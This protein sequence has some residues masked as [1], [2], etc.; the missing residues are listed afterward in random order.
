MTRCRLVAL[1]VD[2]TLMSYDGVIS[3]EVRA[4]VRAVRESGVH[5]VLATGRGVHSAAPVAMDLGLTEGWVVC[6]N[7]AVTARLDPAVDKG[8]EIVRVVTFD[9]GPAL[10]TIA[11]ELPDALFAVEDLGLGFRVSADFPDGELSGDLEV[12]SWEELTATPATRV[13]IRAPGSTPELFHELVERVGLH[14]V[15]YAVGWSAW[16]D[17][18]PGGVSKASALEEVRQHLG[19]Q[20]HATVAIGDGGNDLQMLRWAARG[21]AMGHAPEAVRLAADEVTGSI[22]DDGALVVLRSLLI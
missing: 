18:T 17:L 1:D 2:G 5:V 16:L 15:E 9:P 21:V 8:Y 6:S 4:A 3:D 12:V 10:R 7:G 20:P 19:V 11:L 22:D 13:V 14:E